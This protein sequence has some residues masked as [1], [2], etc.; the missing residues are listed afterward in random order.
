MNNTSNIST[1][2]R[3]PDNLKNAKDRKKINIL[4]KQTRFMTS[5]IKDRK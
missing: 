5:D 2:L 3:T 4:T 1:Y